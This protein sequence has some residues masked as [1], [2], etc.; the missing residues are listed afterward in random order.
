VDSADVLAPPSVT[1][2]VGGRGSKRTLSW[3]LRRVP[4]QRVIFTETGRDSA[5]VITKTAAARGS[6]RFTP[7]DGNG[8]A[9]KIT[10]LVQQSG[11]PRAA[12]T[13]ARYTAPPWRKPARPRRLRVRRSGSN[14]LVS[15]RRA[16]GAKRY[17]VFVKAA[18]GEREV[19]FVPARKRRLKVRG[20][21]KD[22]RALVRVAG[23]RSDNTV[24]ALATRRVKPAR[25]R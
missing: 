1:A 18:D 10:A 14:L 9:R 21:Q 7:A 24:G 17:M 8:R 3:R 2:R 23:L 12:L 6:V 11:A 25:R 19:F 22:D 16:A 15:W 13:V 20:V 4:G 5:H